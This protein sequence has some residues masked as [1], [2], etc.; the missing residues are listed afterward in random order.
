MGRRTYGTNVNS[1][2]NSLEDKI[3]D[4][5]ESN[6]INESESKS[7]V[8][9]SIKK[10]LV[11]IFL[12]I[13]S[14]LAFVIFLIRIVDIQ[15][16]ASHPTDAAKGYIK[17]IL[18][19]EKDSYQRYLPLSIRNSGYIADNNNISEF[20]ILNEKY[21]IDLDDI[22]VVIDT[23]SLDI[24]ELESNLLKL[25]K[26]DI[27]I[28]DA[29]KL[30]VSTNMS[31]KVDGKLYES[32]LVFN[33]ISIKVGFKWY[34]YTGI[35]TYGDDVIQPDIKDDD[36][37]DESTSESIFEDKIEDVTGDATIEYVSPV[38]K[39]LKPLE[40][41]D[42]VKTDLI[43]GHVNID[44]VDYIFP[45][46]YNNMT[47]LYVLVDDS[48]EEDIRSIEPN[49]ILKN[50]PISF[51]N[52]DYG[53]TD[54]HISIANA[55]DEHIDV[56]DGLVTTFYIG[57]PKSKYSYQLYDY[58]DIYLPG[59]ITLTSSYDDVKSMYGSLERYEN[60]NNS[61]YLYSDKVDIY[62]VNLY[63]NRCNKIYFE[64]ENN[65]LVAIQW[66]FYDLNMF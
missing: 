29:V 55:T 5:N 22:V 24:D 43:N 30:S 2:T 58:P 10:L 6:D 19:G 56:S 54:F 52:K 3:F 16:G 50:L 63:G 1:N 31:Y 13:V 33:L 20:R 66:Y 51:V 11:I 62:Y 18:S 39:D 48:I 61:L 46:M 47:S 25:Y 57:L 44:G 45:S 32:D 53:M 12:I 26:T 64:F 65:M 8:K 4:I 59:N 28:K 37:E 38:N 15:G 49:Y 27:S 42:N 36:I 34:I 35:E 7:D 14:I 17:A 9:F 40:K 60:N 21:D 23:T 41:Y